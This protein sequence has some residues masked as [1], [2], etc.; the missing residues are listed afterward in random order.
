MPQFMKYSIACSWGKFIAV[1]AAHAGTTI[2]CGCG[3]PVKVPSLSK[4]REFAGKNAYEAG[5]IDVINGM[6]GRGELP[7]GTHCAVSGEPTDAILE[8]Q[9]QAERFYR[10]NNDHA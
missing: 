5:M 9:V 2:D 3:A 8:L 4:L 7:T 6:L 10:T 1:P